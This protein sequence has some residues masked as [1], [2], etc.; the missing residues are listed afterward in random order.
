MQMH[1][2]EKLKD[3]YHPGKRIQH[4]FTIPDRLHVLERF[5][6]A[7]FCPGLKAGHNAFVNTSF[8]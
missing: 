8:H 4:I 3:G 1:G 6:K 2:S 7:L 5:L